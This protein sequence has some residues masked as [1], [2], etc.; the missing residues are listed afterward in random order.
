MYNLLGVCL[1]SL[2]SLLAA[3]PL[4]AQ[5]VAGLGIK[6]I[7]ETNCISCHTADEFREDERSVKAWELT[8]ANMRKYASYTDAEA[9][10]LVDYLAGA[11]FKHDYFPASPP[12]DHLAVAVSSSVPVQVPP[13]VQPPTPASPAVHT[14]Q[15]KADYR[16]QLAADRFWNPSPVFLRL[17]RY[18]GYGGIACLLL[19]AVT[20]LTRRRLALRFKPVHN[21]LA[22]AFI[23]LMVLHTGIY[24][25]KYGTP[26]VLWLWFGIVASVTPIVSEWSGL[27]RRRLQLRFKPVHYGTGFACLV[28]SVLH[29]IWAWL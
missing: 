22:L 2:F 28:F 15:W 26:P 19:L 23:V 14:A 18:F 7:F 25:C 20:G 16:K 12:E 5:D 27:V 13:V 1:W 24:L 4:R 10:Q 3:S 29:W 21:T 8:I 11:G 17:A 6:A 9:Q